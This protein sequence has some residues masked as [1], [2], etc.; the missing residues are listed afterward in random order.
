V[1]TSSNPR[2]SGIDLG[3]IIA[4]RKMIVY[5]AAGVNNDHQ[6]YGFGVR[7]G[8]FVFKGNSTTADFVFENATGASS[9]TESARINGN[10]TMN[11]KATTNQL[12]LGSTRTITI[13]APTPAT[14]S[15]T[16]TIPDAGTNTNF[17]VSDSAS[18]QNINS[19]LV[20]TGASTHPLKIKAFKSG[21]NDT[22][23]GF[24]DSTANNLK[25]HWQ[26]MGTN[27]LSITESSVADGRIY[28]KK[29]GFVGINTTNPS[30]ALDIV[31]SSN[32]SGTLTTGSITG[33]G[34]IPVIG[35][36]YS[37][38]ETGQ[39]VS[40]TL[41]LT[42]NYTPLVFSTNASKISRLVQ[43]DYSG[44]RQWCG[45]M[46]YAVNASTNR[47]AL[48]GGTSASSAA[49]EINLYTAANT[50]TA[51]DTLV[52]Q[53]NSNNATF[54]TPVTVNGSIS[55]SSVGITPT[56]GTITF[57]LGAVT[58]DFGYSY[59]KVGNVVH[60]R[61]NYDGL[62]MTAAAN[63]R[64][65]IPLGDVLPDISPVNETAG[66]FLFGESGAYT[67]SAYYT[68]PSGNLWKGKSVAGDSFTTGN[69]VIFP[70]QTL[71]WHL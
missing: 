50:T 15:R 22:L 70:T 6:Y 63:S 41:Q 51:S 1:N 4:D 54:N 11:I 25:W 53:F 49:T 57:T 31:G 55:A 23:L 40:G 61:I 30:V 8:T 20:V 48:G 44:T 67:S 10:G 18:N 52:A 32:V 58:K 14:A 65:I 56:S 7:T 13:T 46:L 47:L 38:P 16:Y 42:N 12:V 64:L 35:P 45:A 59:T 17:I 33:S 71:T 39:V 21:T 2:G 28:L 26:M 5:Q 66:T 43:Y 29:G 36:G 3:N 9:S 69:N 34:S 24:Y 68:A 19:G 27:D 37:T 60:F 62:G